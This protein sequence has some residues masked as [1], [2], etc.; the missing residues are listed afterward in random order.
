MKNKYRQNLILRLNKENDMK[1]KKPKL[2]AMINVKTPPETRA[3][4]Q[5]QADKYA[6]GNLSAWLRHAG[7]QYTPKKGE[8]VPLL[9]GLNF[10]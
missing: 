10:Y 6:N 3:R 8:S 1:K 2:L 4:L 9:R 7:L 5:A